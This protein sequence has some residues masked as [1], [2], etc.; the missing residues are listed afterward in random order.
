MNSFVYVGEG[1][2][3]M[4]SAVNQLAFGSLSSYT[5]PGSKMLIL[6]C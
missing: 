1:T 3:H 2:S 4:D 5:S 6:K